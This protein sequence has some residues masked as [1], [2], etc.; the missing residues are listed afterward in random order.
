MAG[1]INGQSVIQIAFVVKDIEESSRAFSQLLGNQPTPVRTAGDYSITQTILDGKPASEAN[2]WMAFLD[3]GNGVS[4]ELI[5]PNGKP[6]VW[7]EHLE[8]K[9]PG[10]HHIAFLTEDMAQS[11]QSC[12]DAGLRMRQWGRFRDGSGEYAYLEGTDSLNT[13]VELL[14]RY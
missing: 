2:C 7:Q 9:G 1:L 14:A 11:V 8:K 4:I 12:E 6:S 3:A 5:Q 13:F 10:F